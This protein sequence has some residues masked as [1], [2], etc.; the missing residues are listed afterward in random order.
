MAQDG[1]ERSA[2]PAGSAT[3]PVDAS[4]SL[5]AASVPWQ[6]RFTGAVALAHATAEGWTLL[7]PLVV[8]A[9]INHEIERPHLIVHR[10]QYYLFFS[11]SRGA[12]HPPHSAPTGLYGFVAPTLNGPYEPLNGS[13]LVLQNPPA[14]PDQA[15]A[16]V[17]LA[18]LSVVSF[19]NYLSAN[20]SHHI[21]A[22]AAEARARWGHSRP[23]TPH[24]PR[25]PQIGTVSITPDTNAMNQTTKGGPQL[26]VSE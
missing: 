21:H 7:P 26:P 6:D 3:P 18:D 22:P 24:R 19:I 20:G 11:T 10:G 9:G 23:G 16:W 1:S 2:T 4:L 12:F 17:V 15:Y 25:R 8:A 13:G 5:V 14:Q